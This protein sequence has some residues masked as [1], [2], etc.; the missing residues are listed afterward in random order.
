MEKHKGDKMEEQQDCPSEIS[1]NLPDQPTQVVADDGPS[2]SIHIIPQFFVDKPL[3]M[4]V[5]I[6]RSL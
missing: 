4:P 1:I 2:P 5:I 3:S 6:K